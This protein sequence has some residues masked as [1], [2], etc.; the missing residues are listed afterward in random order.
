[1]PAPV[2][3]LDLTGAIR[4]PDLSMFETTLKGRV[5]CKVCKVSGKPDD[6]WVYEHLAGHPLKCE[7]I[8]CTKVFTKN[9]VFLK[10]RLAKHPELVPVEDR[11]TRTAR[12][13]VERRARFREA[14]I[15]EE[16]A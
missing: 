3:A 16:A 8:G 5:R 11:A 15:S 4:Y 14:G 13:K 6:L 10:H 9:A 1:M 7:A 12:L 2:S